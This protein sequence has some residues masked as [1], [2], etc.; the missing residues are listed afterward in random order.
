MKTVH[1]GREIT[2]DPV[3]GPDGAAIDRLTL[4]LLAARGCG[5]S[6]CPS[7]VARALVRDDID[8]DW[9]GAM[10]AVHDAVDRLVTAGEIRLSWKGRLLDVRQ[11]PYRIRKPSDD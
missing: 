8:R 5:A 6:V 7:E 3:M 9:R 10:P 2:A 4:E 11:G 1:K